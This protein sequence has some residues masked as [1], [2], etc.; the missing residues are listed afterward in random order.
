MEHSLELTDTYIFNICEEEPKKEE[1]EYIKSCSRK[2][3]KEELRALI[4]KLTDYSTKKLDDTLEE[5]KKLLSL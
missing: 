5:V 3:R 2:T 4:D 1:D